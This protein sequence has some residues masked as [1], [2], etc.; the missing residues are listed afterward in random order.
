LLLLV[1]S[2][3][4]LLCQGSQLCLLKLLLHHL[5]LHR[6]LLK[7]LLLLLVCSLRCCLLLLVGSMR[8]HGGG[9]GLKSLSL[10][11]CTTHQR[12]LRGFAAHTLL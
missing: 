9:L 11:T 7:S 4:R 5:L 3:S 2:Q 10:H 12:E 1:C 8:L 6:L